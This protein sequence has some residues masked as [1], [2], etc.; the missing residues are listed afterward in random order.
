MK[1]IQII[2]TFDS[3]YIVFFDKISIKIQRSNDDL[4]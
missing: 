4:R 3:R 2:K 1:L